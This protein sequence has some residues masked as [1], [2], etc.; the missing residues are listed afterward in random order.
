MGG[1]KLYSGTFVHVRSP[2]KALTDLE[3]AVPAST[4]YLYA[5]ESLWS[6]LI[7][8]EGVLEVGALNCIKCPKAFVHD[9][10]SKTSNKE[11]ARSPNDLVVL[12]LRNVMC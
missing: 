11:L 10:R 12:L 8:F 7:Q 4:D 2:F 1:P 3:E 5:F 9:V 6:P